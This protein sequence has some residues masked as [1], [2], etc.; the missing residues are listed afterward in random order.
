MDLSEFLQISESGKFKWTGT[1]KDLGNFLSVQGYPGTWSQLENCNGDAHK[2]T[3]S[4]TSGKLF[5]TWFS[6]SK[7]KTLMIQ[8]KKLSELKGKLRQILVHR[9]PLAAAGDESETLETESMEAVKEVNENSIH[10]GLNPGKRIADFLEFKMMK[11]KRERAKVTI[12]TPFMDKSGLDFIMSCLDN[13][14]VLDKVYTR[15]DCAWDKKFDQVID[16]CGLSE[17][18]IKRKVICFKKSKKIP[19][20][21]A[22][23]LAGVYRDKNKVELILTS[24]NMTKEH[25]LSDQLETVMETECDVLTFDR[26]WLKPLDEMAG[27]EALLYG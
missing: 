18:W 2:Y 26:D 23:F 1:Q 13:E 5:C 27:E 16:E 15:E 8:G 4:T 9:T 10:D 22:K 20:F 21:H 17:H 19:S 7:S 3:I 11:W 12:A 6:G 24:S 14:T 25:L